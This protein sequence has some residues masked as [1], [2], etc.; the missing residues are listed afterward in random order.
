MEQKKK[1]LTTSLV[2]FV[3]LYIIVFNYKMA[4]EMREGAMSTPPSTP[5][6]NAVVEDVAASSKH[7]L[8][9]PET[10]TVESAPPAPVASGAGR[11]PP[12]NKVIY[13]PPLQDV[14]L[15]Q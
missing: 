3:L 10:E 15:A 2:L 7:L 6:P 8:A 13:E 12:S 11:E 9:L 5:A 14:I 1:M 4:N